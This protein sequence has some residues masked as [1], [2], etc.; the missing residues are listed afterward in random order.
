LT[1]LLLT[2]F[3]PFGEY[4]VNPSEK[5][6]SELN[7][8]EIAQIQIVGK[9]VSLNYKSINSEI[10]QMIEKFDP[11]I[12]INMGQAP[13]SAISIERIAI[14]L[15]NTTKTAYNCGSKPKDEYLER[16]GPAAYFSTL[17]VT[18][19][20]EFLNNNRIP[21]YTSYSAGTFGC[22]QI[23]YHSLHHLNTKRAGEGKRAGF[24]H[25]PLLPEQA[26]GIPQLSSMGF[27]TM[28]EG[29]KLIISR[30]GKLNTVEKR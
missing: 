24:I 2:G 16:K 10:T 11:D 9:S 22:N 15:A 12:I 5:I 21:C 25:L 8:K 18:H 26:I 28:M 14:N 27:H 19:L 13:R 6:A 29:I 17:P 3:V 30:L 23:M 1:T 20:V 4:S 7:R